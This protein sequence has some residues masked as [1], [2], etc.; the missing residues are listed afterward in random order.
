M[1]KPLLTHRLKQ[2]HQSPTDWIGIDG[3]HGGWVVTHL[4]KSST[5]HS[6]TI[7]SLRPFIESA[8]KQAVILIDMIL[9][10]NDQP[11]SRAFDRIAKKMLGKWHSRVFPAPPLT[12]LRAKTYPEACQLSQLAMGKKISIQCYNLFPKIKELQAITDT[13]LK[14]YHPEIAFMQLNNGSVLPESKKTVEGRKKRMQI[15]EQHLPNYSNELA[16]MK[17]LNCKIDD[18]LD[19][20]AL[21]LVAQTKDYKSFY[22]ELKHPT[23]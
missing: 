15:I 16:S 14:E 22:E 10:L 13:R 9:D 17:T 18:L 6:Y 5:P 2:P 19:S 8:P 12:A 1:T 7:P 23:T 21:A 11:T 20:V 3:C 4:S